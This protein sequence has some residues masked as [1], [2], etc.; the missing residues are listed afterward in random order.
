MGEEQ[1]ILSSKVTKHLIY[2]YALLFYIIFYFNLLLYEKYIKQEY[3]KCIYDGK[4]ILRKKKKT[5]KKRE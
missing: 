2:F 3:L 4:G 1:R 5:R